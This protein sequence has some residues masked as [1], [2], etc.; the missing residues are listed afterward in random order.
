[1]GML[2]IFPFFGKVPTVFPNMGLSPLESTGVHME[3]QRN[4][5][6][7]LKYSQR[8]LKTSKEIQR[9]LKEIKNILKDHLKLESSY[10]KSF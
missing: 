5:Q 7:L 4:R 2:Y 10:L 8:F 9:H 3:Y 6:D 1:M